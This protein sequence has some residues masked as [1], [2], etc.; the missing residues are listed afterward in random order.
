[1]IKKDLSNTRILSHCWISN[2]QTRQWIYQFSKIRHCCYT[3]VG[4][5]AEMRRKVDPESVQLSLQY[6]MKRPYFVIDCN[7]WKNLDIV[8]F[9]LKRFIIFIFFK[10]FP[11]F[12][13]C[14]DHLPMVVLKKTGWTKTCL[15]EMIDEL[16]ST[17]CALVNLYGEISKYE[18]EK[19]ICASHS[20][21]ILLLRMHFQHFQ[22]ARSMV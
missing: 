2:K 10:N 4:D 14:S 7:W 11:D 15:Q 8:L 1:M 13:G 21:K 9:L 20:T 16:L 19:D 18:G 12:K 5:Q 22:I 17:S 3:H 6:I